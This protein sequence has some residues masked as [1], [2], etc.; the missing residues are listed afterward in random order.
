MRIR[1][2]PRSAVICGASSAN[3]GWRKRDAVTRRSMVR[4]TDAMTSF[5]V[6]AYKRKVNTVDATPIKNIRP[7]AAPMYPNITRFANERDRGLSI[8]QRVAHAAYRV[9]Q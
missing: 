5:D 2:R 4:V 8:V 6:R 3:E 1:G 9:N 7:T